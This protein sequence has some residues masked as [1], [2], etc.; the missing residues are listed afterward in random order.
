[1]RDIGIDNYSVDNMDVTFITQVVC[2]CSS[3]V[4]VNKQTREALTKLRD[5]R[6]LTNHSNE[7]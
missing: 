5:D 2:F 7:N 3:V 1:M 6:N 4:T